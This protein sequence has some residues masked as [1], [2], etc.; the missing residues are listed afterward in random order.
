M[1]WRKEEWSDMEQDGVAAEAN[2]VTKQC[3]AT[4]AH[5]ALGSAAEGRG[6][7]GARGCARRDTKRRRV[8]GIALRGTRVRSVFRVRKRS[9]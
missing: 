8:I 3:V 2:I 6:L 9:G 1:E 5:R 4:R 7:G